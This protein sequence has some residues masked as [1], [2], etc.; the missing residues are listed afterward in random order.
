M[1]Q[2]TRRQIEQTILESSG[3]LIRRIAFCVDERCRLQ[4]DMPELLLLHPF[5]GLFSRTTWV[6]RYQ[7]GKTSLIL[8]RQE[9]MGFWDV[10]GISWTI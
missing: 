1:M 4:N 3:R 8:M 6:N 9:M 2:S 10:N 5:N 7:K